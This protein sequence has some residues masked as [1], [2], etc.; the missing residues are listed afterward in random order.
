[1]SDNNEITIAWSAAVHQLALAGG[2]DDAGEKLLELV[3]SGR[4]RCEPRKALSLRSAYK[5]RLFD[6]KT[7]EWRM[8]AGDDRPSRLRIFEADLTRYL[9]PKTNQA[10]RAPYDYM[11]EY[12]ALIHEAIDNFSINDDNQP[13]AEVLTAWFKNKIVD[14]S[15]VSDN[16]ASA[17]TTIVRKAHRKKAARSSAEPGLR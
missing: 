11:P 3:E 7:G 5:S 4:V 14:G 10:A 9:G 13:K 1:M 15:K 6:I 17:M 2:Q 12:L 16:L 8:H